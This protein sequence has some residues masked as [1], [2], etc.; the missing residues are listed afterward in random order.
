MLPSLLICLFIFEVA[1]AGTRP[2]KMTSF[3]WVGSLDAWLPSQRA[4]HER[5][6]PFANLATDS[7]RGTSA[8]PVPIPKRPA[9]DSTQSSRDYFRSMSAANVGRSMSA[10]SS[11]LSFFGAETSMCPAPAASEPQSCDSTAQSYCGEDDDDDDDIL[12]LASSLSPSEAQYCLLDWRPCQD[13][14][15]PGIANCSSSDCCAHATASPM[16]CSRGALSQLLAESLST[17]APSHTA[18]SLASA[19]SLPAECSFGRLCR[20]WAAQYVTIK[21][22]GKQMPQGLR[23]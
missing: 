15:S 21:H 23:S 6:S 12:A 11:L 13:T 10:T 18:P 4:T 8:K 17:S 9:K 5:A 2:T 19:A 22:I 1:D 20:F 7:F 3:D 16:R 14:T